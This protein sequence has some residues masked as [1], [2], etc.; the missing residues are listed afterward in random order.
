[1]WEKFDVTE[2]VIPLSN[3]NNLD[4]NVLGKVVVLLVTVSDVENM[5]TR[6]YLQPLDGHKNIYKF[7][8]CSEHQME[9]AIYFIGKYGA[10]PAAIRKI[11]PGS[12]VLGG[13]VSVPRMAYNCFPNLGVIIGVGVACGVEKKV[14]MCDV[15]VSSKVINYDKG[16]AQNERFIP[17]EVID[18]SPHLNKLFSQPVHW[19]NDSIKKRLNDS[20]M[21]IPTIRSGIILS[22]PY[23]IDGPV[24][25]ELL[26]EDFAHEAIGIEIERANLFAATQLTTSNSIIV[27]AVCD[28]GD[29]KKSKEYQ[30]T[31]ALMAADFVNKYLSDPDVPKILNRIEG[32]EIVNF[33]YV[34]ICRRYI[35][36]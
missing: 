20:G 2:E 24:M 12:E 17:R 23:L 25:K 31:A 10:C 13:A 30:P 19:P 11:P 27:K 18:T 7:L 36:M 26:I 35:C 15:L 6:S 3:E 34:Y 33:P 8:Q 5:A 22:G 16:M 28:F 1:L 4:A 29:G 32:I 9:T 14:N 21:P